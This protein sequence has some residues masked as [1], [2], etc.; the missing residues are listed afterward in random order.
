MRLRKG[1]KR[2][3]D[4]HDRILDR[5]YNNGFHNEKSQD[6]N[7]N[8]PFVFQGH[9]NLCVDSCV[10]MMKL[11]FNNN[12]YRGKLD[13][14]LTRLPTQLDSY[15]IRN[16]PRGILSG[17]DGTDA[18]EKGTEL[19]LYLCSSYL[20]EDDFR[21][22]LYY[23]LTQHGPFIVFY[24]MHGTLV[25]GVVN[26]KVITHDAWHGGNLALTSSSFEKKLSSTEYIYQL[27]GNV[28]RTLP[29]ELEDKDETYK[30]KCSIL[31]SVDGYVMNYKLKKNRGFI[32]YHGASGCNRMM[33]F[34]INLNN[35]NSTHEVLLEIEKFI[36]KSGPY[37]EFSGRIKLH[38]SSGLTFILHGL[39]TYFIKNPNPQD[40]TLKK[41]KRY[42]Q[43]SVTGVFDMDWHLA[44]RKKLAGLLGNYHMWA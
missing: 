24:P 34:A 27:R 41:A 19:G 42:F 32:N 22:R 23:A 36:H 25:K 15:R 10:Y 7:F 17:M 3:V 26:D 14:D 31:D 35:K 29:E 39:M 20:P 2:F 12:K 37:S 18:I 1:I 30:L 43:Q 4:Q 9:I 5:K 16:N 13:K 21:S 11:F 44:T 38:K 33:T 40:A 28:N 6:I 8:V